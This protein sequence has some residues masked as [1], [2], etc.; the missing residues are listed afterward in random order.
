ME[1]KAGLCCVTEARIASHER[2][3]DVAAARSR[4]YQLHLGHVSGAKP[5]LRSRPSKVRRRSVCT[6]PPALA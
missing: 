2:Q 3:S 5:S 4:G 6:A 1:A